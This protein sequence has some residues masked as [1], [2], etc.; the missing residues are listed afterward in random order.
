[1]AAVEGAIM[2]VRAVLAFSLAAL[3][4]VASALAQDLAAQDVSASAEPGPRAIRP[5]TAPVQGYTYFNRLGATLENQRADIDACREVVLAMSYTGGATGSSVND[6]VVQSVANQNIAQYGAAGAVGSIIGM[7][8]VVGAEMEAAWRRSAHANYENCMVARG[9]RVVVLED[10]AGRELDRLNDRALAERLEAMVG[11]EPQGA[12]AR[13][14]TNNVEF[15]VQPSIDTT[16]FSLQILPRTYFTRPRRGHESTTERRDRVRAEQELRATLAQAWRGRQAIEPLNSEALEVLPADAA[17]VIVGARDQAPLFVRVGAGTEADV[18]PGPF[19]DADDK[20]QQPTQVGDG[21][22]LRMYVVTPGTWRLTTLGGMTS[23]CFGAPSFDI[24]AGE[25]VFVGA[26]NRAGPDFSLDAARALLTSRPELAARARAASFVNG[27]TF[28]CGG[29]AAFPYAHEIEG[30]PF[31]EGYA[32]G[33]RAAVS[34]SAAATEASDVDG[35]Q[36]TQAN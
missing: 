31:V 18:F 4:I 26:W 35:A 6:P 27:N 34:A 15:N 11:S 29:G 33:S 28:E 25:V 5:M 22:P 16:S 14:F 8:I 21:P 3:A 10:E 13:T 20:E 7:A 1:M 2:R 36:G 32:W 9:W 24:A 23:F 19:A 17:I 30:A 12:V